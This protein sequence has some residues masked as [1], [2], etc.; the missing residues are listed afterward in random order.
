MG[1]LDP[2]KSVVELAADSTVKLSGSSAGFDD[3][4]PITPAAEPEFTP[5]AYLYVAAVGVV[6]VLT[7]T[8]EDR[9]YPSGALAVGP[10]PL[11][12]TKVF[13]DTTATVFAAV[14]VG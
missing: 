12:V 11:R 4:I 14:T 6:H 13:S 10:T 2:V 8:G 3:L 1:A 5:Y 9:L 7:A